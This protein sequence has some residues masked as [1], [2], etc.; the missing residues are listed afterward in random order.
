MFPSQGYQ[1][2]MSEGE[3]ESPTLDESADQPL[4]PLESP[5]TEALDSEVKEPLEEDE[6]VSD[7]I[8][9]SLPETNVVLQ[10]LQNTEVAVAQ[11]PV[12]TSPSS[13]QM[14]PAA[15]QTTLCA[16]QQQQ[17]MLLHVIQQLQSQITGNGGTSS[18]LP[19]LVPPITGSLPSESPTDSMEC[20][21]SSAPQTNSSTPS[22]TAVAKNAK[23]SSPLSTS[24]NSTPATTAYSSTVNTPTSVIVT[25]NTGKTNDSAKPAANAVALTDDGSQIPLNASEISPSAPNE[26]NTLELLQRHTEQA[27]QNTMSGSS[28]LVN[29]ISGIG[30]SDFLKFRK[31][32]KEDP[33]FRHRCRFCGKVFGSDS[34]LQIHIRSHT[35]ERPFKCNVCGN[36][37]STKGNLKVHFQRHKAKYPHVKMNPHPAITTTAAMVPT[38][39]GTST[40]TAVLGN[41]PSFYQDLLPKPGSTDNSWESLMEIQ[42]ASETCKLQQL[43]DNI[44]H[45]MTDPN[46]CVICHRVLSCKSALQMH[47]RTHTGERPFKCKICGRAFTTKGNLKTHM[48]VHRVKPPL[49]ILHQCPVCHKQFTNALVLQQH[50]R[51]HTGEPT[52]IP[53]EH[54]MANE[55]IHPQMLPPSF[56]RPLLPSFTNHPNPAPGMF[57]GLPNITCVP[58]L[59]TSTATSTSMTIPINSNASSVDKDKQTPKNCKQLNSSQKSPKS[60]DEEERLDRNSVSP[61]ASDA[62]NSPPSPAESTKSDASSVTPKNSSVPQTTGSETMANSGNV[63][64]STSLAALENHVKT[65]NSSVPTTMPFG[66]FSLGLHQ[67]SQYQ[68]F[69]ALSDSTDIRSQPEPSSRPSDLS[70]VS[71]SQERSPIA[72]QAFSPASMTSKETSLDGE[73]SADERLSPCSV[74]ARNH[75]ESL[76]NPASVGALDLT[77][78]PSQSNHKQSSTTPPLLSSSMFPTPFLGLSFPT[79]RPNTT[80]QICFKTFAC[81]SALEIHYRSHTKERPF[82]CNYCDRGFSTKGNMK[83]HMLTHKIRDMPP[84]LY[85]TTTSVSSSVSFTTN[86]NS[87]ASVS[88]NSNGGVE[89]ASESKSSPTTPNG[90]GESEEKKCNVSNSSA[91][92]NSSTPKHVCTDCNKPFS[93]HSALQIHTRTHTGDKPFKCTVCGRAFTTKG[94]LKVHMGTHMWNNGLSRRGRRMSIDL[95]NLH[96][97]PFHNF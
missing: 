40:S 43:V 74:S 24:T 47:Y 32:G 19:F 7:W 41:D 25:A 93:S 31:D 34:A 3:E 81:N 57:P 79:G 83:Q 76:S 44:E 26:P 6:E 77:P 69:A 50:I 73:V 90:N 62:P 4:E 18:V 53:P 49:R 54:I 16:L 96:I 56:H 5:E 21:T 48:G 89:K 52:D 13:Q 9:S 37:F 33:S 66:P 23:T 2:W 36:R 11:H 63:S 39:N 15:I 82:K 42:K 60:E 61:A 95:P 30:S 80:C 14:P 45:K 17:F 65:I 78:K 91:N 10:S 87:N 51:M 75:D 58:S 85:T 27:L 29:G 84:G 68:R 71:Q 59:L 8:P 12:A 38:T 46:Q 20:E 88:S 55:I 97:T 86:T 64:F 72:S 94:N 67:F 28:F 35:G 22:L 70:Q 1:H 92:S